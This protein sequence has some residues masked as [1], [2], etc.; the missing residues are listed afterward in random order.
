MYHQWQPTTRDIQRR[1]KLNED[2][3]NTIKKYT[4]ELAASVGTMWAYDPDMNYFR[5][6]P[7]NAP[8]IAKRM[9]QYQLQHWRDAGQST[10]YL[11][12]GA[13]QQG[14]V[15]KRTSKNVTRIDQQFAKQ[16]KIIDEEV[17]GL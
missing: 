7:D 3:V 10:A 11:F 9:L 8:E 17:K 16:I 4:K 15:A 5:V 1:Y 14:Y 2:Q 13:E 12:K 6:A